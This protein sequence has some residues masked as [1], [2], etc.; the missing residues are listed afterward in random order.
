MKPKNYYLIYISTATQH[1]SNDALLELLAKSRQNNAKLGVTGMLLYKDDL[2]Q[3]I[4]EGPEAVVKALFAKIQLDPRHRGVI[5]AL[6]GFED[7]RQFTE[8]SMGF[9]DLNSAA[10]AAVPG[11][12]EFLN[13][14]LTAGQ[15]LS[16]PG[17]CRRFM[18]MFKQNMSV[19]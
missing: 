7:G 10:A 12:S 18:L 19:G 11:Y 15:F 6:E 2:F 16:N 5:K 4:L 13:T 17:I 8:W 14:P 9:C 1:F 3:Q